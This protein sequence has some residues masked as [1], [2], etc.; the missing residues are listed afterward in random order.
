MLTSPQSNTK[1]KPEYESNAQ[2]C[3]T[4]IHKTDPNEMHRPTT[5]CAGF[6]QARK[7]PG[8][9]HTIGHGMAN[10]QLLGCPAHTQPARAACA[11]HCGR[12]KD[13]P[14]LTSHSFRRTSLSHC[15]VVGGPSER[16]ALWPPT[17][18]PMQ[19]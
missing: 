7:M 1:V 14:Q 13:H 6:S 12:Q 2:I 19:P 5:V 16:L 17:H 18:Q 8:S 9:M 10:I 15:T 3:T 11:V 4:C